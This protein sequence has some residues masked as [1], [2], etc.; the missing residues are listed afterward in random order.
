MPPVRG[1]RC[2]VIAE[3]ALT[4]SALALAALAVLVVEVLSEDDPWTAP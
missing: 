3:A 4:W 2:G 1:W